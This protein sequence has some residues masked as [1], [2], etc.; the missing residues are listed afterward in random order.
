MMPSLMAATPLSDIWLRQRLSFCNVVV[1][2]ITSDI[3]L[4]HSSLISFCTRSSSFND[5]PFLI[6]SLITPTPLTDN[7]LP[8]R[9]SICNVVTTC[10]ALAIIFALSM[11]MN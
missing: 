9:S 2:S 8:L 11:P 6:L 1:T 5:L 7:P 4:A 3:I 10:M